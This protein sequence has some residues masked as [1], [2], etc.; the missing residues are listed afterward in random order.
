M[1]NGAIERRRR[2]RTW[3]LRLV[4]SV[5]VC[6]PAAHAA[7]PHFTG[8]NILTPVIGSTVNLRSQGALSGSAPMQ[9]QSVSVLPLGLGVRATVVGGVCVEITNALGIDL[10]SV[11]ALLSVVVSNPEAPRGVRGTIAILPGLASN[12]DLSTCVDPRKAPVANAG[13][14]LTVADSDSA[15]GEVV[16]LDGSASSDPDGT[17]T[18]YTWTDVSTG[19]TLGT[20]PVIQPRMTDGNHQVRLTVVDNSGGPEGTASTLI[21]VVVQAPQAG[22]PNNPAAPTPNAGPNRSLLDTDG[23]LGELVTLDASASISVGGG[24]IL[25]YEWLDSSQNLLGVG[26][27]LSVRLPDGV[28]D[29]TL[30]VTGSNLLTST[31]RLV[32]TVAAPLVGNLLDSI[33]NLTPNQHAVATAVDD[34]CARLEQLASAQ[35]LPAEQID[36]FNRCS[37]IIGTAN[38][39]DQINALDELG[40]NDLIAIRTQAL[41]FSNAQYSGVMDRLVAMRSGARGVNLNLGGLTFNM[42]GKPVSLSQIEPLIQKFWEV[43]GGGRD[44]SDPGEPLLSDK[45]GIWVRG[46]RDLGEKEVSSQSDGFRGRQWG[47]TGGVDYRLGRQSV[48]GVAFGYGQSDIDFR[49]ANRGGLDS[50]SWT[51]SLYGSTYPLGNFYVD[52]VVNYG[53]ADYDT[54]RHIV[55]SEGG[56]PIDRTAVGRTGGK[57]LSGGL[58]VGYDWNVGGFTFSPMLGYFHTRAEVDSF[59]E[60]GASGLDLAYDD[61]SYSSST[62]NLSFAVNYAWSTKWFV[63]SPHVRGEYL[64]ELNNDVEVFGVRFAHD[65]FADSSNPTPPIIVRSDTPDQWYWRLA[66]GLSA[67]FKYG[68]SGYV[69]YQRLEDFQFVSFEN[70]TVG[71]RFQ[72]SV[73]GREP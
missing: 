28:N 71:L 52:A 12:N 22:G 65:P 23:L 19:Q 57:T 29:I 1:F 62:A 3:L 6:S 58:S 30:R 31:T 40:A 39:G 54:A 15:P 63:L 45:L 25:S 17:I 32:V 67:Q 51:A 13:G 21:N 68:I 73:G 33:Q 8:L 36:L 72:R 18:S 34:L 35:T 14:N 60:S 7:A 42:G 64:H 59:A 66:A 9:I 37:G 47:L 56:T 2:L 48:L 11:G 43:V 53:N 24:S 27:S 20:G 50:T 44:G 4:L 5:F 10:L 70:F 26:V 49:P 61:Q 16:T 41:L 38:T 46:T 69:E 55:Y